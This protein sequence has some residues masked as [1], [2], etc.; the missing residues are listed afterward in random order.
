MASTSSR[1]HAL[2]EHYLQ[3]AAPHTPELPPGTVEGAGGM[4]YLNNCNACRR[5][6]GAG[7]ED[8][9]P[10]LAGNS[11]SNAP[12]CGKPSFPKR[13]HS[14]PR[15]ADRFGLIHGVAGC[16]SHGARRSTFRSTL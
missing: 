5:S 11:V 16:V 12:R 14:K 10:S 8:V 3:P 2:A 4:V 1:C 13:R 9:F 15:D 6:S 7:A